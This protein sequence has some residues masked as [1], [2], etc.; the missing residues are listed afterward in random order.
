MKLTYEDVVASVDAFNRMIQQRLDVKLDTAIRLEKTRRA[1][2][3]H[4][5]VYNAMNAKFIRDHGKQREV[6]RNGKIEKE[7]YIPE[8]DIENQEKY[9][10]DLDELLAREEDVRIHILPDTDKLKLNNA[11]NLADRGALWF[12]LDGIQEE[13]PSKADDQTANDPD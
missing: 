2:T 7:W 3:K 13:E 5:R 1:L 9:W 4:L 6:N 12:L 11:L 8:E 10:V